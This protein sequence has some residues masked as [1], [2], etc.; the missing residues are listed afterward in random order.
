MRGSVPLTC[1]A[2]PFF[3][4]TYIEEGDI[5]RSIKQNLQVITFQIYGKLLYPFSNKP[6]S[7]WSSFYGPRRPMSRRISNSGNLINRI[8]KARDRG[9]RGA[10][11]LRR[12]YVG[13]IHDSLTD[14]YLCRK[15]FP[16]Y[17]FSI[18]IWRC[19]ANKHPLNIKAFADSDLPILSFTIIIRIDM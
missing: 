12:P 14:L 2:A 5:M 18:F 16:F 4:C 8:Y 11:V 10:D 17:I 6:L 19:A 13:L 3:N 7:G 9:Q 1:A 15:L